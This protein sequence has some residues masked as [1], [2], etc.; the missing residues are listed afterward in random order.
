MPGGRDLNADLAALR[1]RY[2]QGK[3]LMEILFPARY[4][5]D[6]YTLRVVR[7]RMAWYTGNFPD[8]GL[9]VNLLSQCGNRTFHI[10][11]RIACL[12]PL[13]ALRNVTR[14]ACSSTILSEP[15]PGAELL[16]QQE[17]HI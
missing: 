10:Q 13:Q 11:W 3:I 6:P 12:S 2:G 8:D 7:P 14:G 16:S 15:L 4:P 17:T 5:V 1:R 9:G